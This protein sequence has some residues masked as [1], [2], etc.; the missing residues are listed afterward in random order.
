MQLFDGSQRRIRQDHLFA[1]LD[2]IKNI[3]YHGKEQCF[4]IVI[5][6]VDGLFADGKFLCQVIHRE[7]Q[8]FPIED[9]KGGIQNVFLQS[10]C[11]IHRCSSVFRLELFLYFFG[12][13]NTKSRFL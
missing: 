8:P 2:R 3:I 5:D 13:S 7:L 1:F 10:I 4:F 11:G 6:G 12:N 9:T